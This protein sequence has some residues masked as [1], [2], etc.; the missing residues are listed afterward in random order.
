MGDTSDY[1]APEIL[2]EGVRSSKEADMYAFG[3]V[4][5]EVITGIRPFGKR[6]EAEVVLH[7]TRG[8]RPNRPEDPV[9]VGFSQGTW[10]FVDQCWD[11]DQERRPT[12]R[13]ALEHFERV[14]KT[15]TVI[16]PGPTIPDHKAAG[17]ASSRLDTDSK[18]Y[19]EFRGHYQV[20]PI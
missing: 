13:E 6:R 12:A 10:E 17:E 16:N 5:Y 1:M 3:I 7:T 9:A 15:S 11:R 20:S 2:R 8:N 14:A 19:C 4:V 18:D